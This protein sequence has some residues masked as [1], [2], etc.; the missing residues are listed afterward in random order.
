MMKDLLK[1]RKGLLVKAGILLGLFVILLFF[2]PLSHAVYFV[3]LASLILFIVV[4]FQA[5]RAHEEELHKSATRTPAKRTM[6]DLP[7]KSAQQ[8]T[9]KEAS[10]NIEEPVGPGPSLFVQE[11]WNTNDKPAQMEE[12]PEAPLLEPSDFVKKIWQEEA[13]N[14]RL[15]LESLSDPDTL[16]VYTP[17]GFVPTI[18]QKKSR[19]AA[20]KKVKKTQPTPAVIANKSA[21]APRR[22]INRATLS[23][24][25]KS[26]KGAASSP[27][28][29]SKKTGKTPK[30]N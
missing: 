27:V 8:E 7:T 20:A 16:L 17:S 23:T 18:L 26:K 21:K 29:P 24:K 2:V 19:K 6:P 28:K 1:K 11:V 13:E 4:K 25:P 22:S 10:T 15:E 14:K 30:N 9:F 12:E 5:R 3:L